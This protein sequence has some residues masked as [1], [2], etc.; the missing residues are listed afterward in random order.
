MLLRYSCWK[1]AKLFENS[2]GPDQTPHSDLD[3]RC[4]PATLLEVSRLKWVKK[5]KRTVNETAK[6]VQ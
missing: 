6:I 4:L 1:M 3:L 2:G 5:S